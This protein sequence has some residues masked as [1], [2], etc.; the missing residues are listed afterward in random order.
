VGRGLFR[1]SVFEKTGL[2]DEELFAGGDD[3]DWFLRAMEKDLRIRVIEE[4]TLFYR[5]HTSN[6]TH[7]KSL[8]ELN[9]FR[10][11]KKSLDRRRAADRGQAKALS[12][13]FERKL[14]SVILPV[15]NG[16]KYL[17]ETIR[18][19]LAQEFRNFEFIAVDDGSTDNSADIIKKYKEIKY[20]YQ[21][22]QG[23]ASARNRGVEESR[24][25]II[26]LIDQDDLWTP[27]KLSLQVRCLLKYPGVFYLVAKQEVFLE[28]GTEKPGWLKED[29]LGRE[30]FGFLLGTVV[31]Y[32]RLFENDNRFNTSYQYASDTDW[33]FR[34]KDAGIPMKH[35]DEVLLKKRVHHSNQSYDVEKIHREIL[36]LVKSSIKRR[37]GSC[38]NEK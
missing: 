26:A 12:K 38:I 1:R 31:G 30:Q 16:G 36:D 18:S 37:K 4:T 17:E 14:V 35:L 27:D 3:M 9:L 33:F 20:I 34:M 13:L 25:E 10:V 2:F 19:V 6:T 7:G 23:V 28:P 32:R 22:N 5:L 29:V 15:F 11:L 21:N 8:Q 24:G